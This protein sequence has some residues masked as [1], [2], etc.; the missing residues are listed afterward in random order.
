[1][2]TEDDVK[3]RT[4]ARAQRPALLLALVGL[5]SMLFAVTSAPAHATGESGVVSFTFDDGRITQY[6]NAR[7]ILNNAG[8]KATF[9]LVGDAFTWG[10]T[11][12][13]ATQARTLAQEGH[14]LGNHTMNHPNL[15]TLSS[16]QIRTEFTN[17]QNAI[18]NATGVTP[19]N[20]AYPYGATN[21]TVQTIAAD[22]FT[23]CR[24]VNGG[25]NT[26][27]TGLYNLRTYYVQTTTTADQIRAAANQAKAN[28]T[29]LILIYHGVGPIQS[30]DD[31]STDT[32]TT[33]IAAVQATGVPIKT[34]AQT[35][36]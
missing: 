24:G 36:D 5:I 11:N 16:S 17:A 26:T 20:C 9:Y 7:P 4:A 29:W 22:Y 15:T 10:S 23:S 34:V 18:A 6:T 25:Q 33:H 13:N 14:E 21:T 32:L 19:T 27:T 1:M 30:P 12:M 2:A 8:V 35:L 28:N 3:A 31:V